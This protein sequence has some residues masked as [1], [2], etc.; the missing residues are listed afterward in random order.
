MAFPAYR[1]PVFAAVLACAASAWAA[2]RRPLDRARIHGLYHDGEFERVLRELAPYGKGECACLRDDSVF[3]EKH[4][5]VV[6]A[7]NPATR[8]LGRYHMFRLLDLAP[9]A[10]L[11]DMYVGEEVDAVFD[12]VRKEHD[13]RAADAAAKGPAPLPAVAR[14]ATPPAGMRPADGRVPASSAPS[15][16]EAP[17]SGRTPASSAPSVVPQAPSSGREP[18]PS[19][20]AY[21]D[22]WTRLPAASA[23]RPQG[24]AQPSPARLSAS[25]SPKTGPARATAPSRRGAAVS[26]RPGRPYTPWDQIAVPA[27]GHPAVSG[28]A[29]ASGKAATAPPARGAAAA[30]SSVGNGSPGALAPDQRERTSA[31]PSDPS[32]AFASASEAVPGNDPASGPEAAA[33]APASAASGTSDPAS[34]RAEA[35][36]ARPAWKEPGLWIGGGAALAALAF[37]LW[38][39]GS[40]GGGP[41]KTYAV[42]A[43]LSK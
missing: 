10:D 18:S 29:P 27:A 6:L 32:P 41:A 35:D 28:S 12:K 36:T 14:S 43:S 39:A 42:P 11:L 37:T 1:I 20:P 38:R 31:I 21:S 40:D 4:L 2:P 9:R 26:P 16:P 19:S 25:R 7:A 3:A 23:P 5:A 22:A 33:P 34:A 30:P 24:S 8:E 13:L 17:S 15:V